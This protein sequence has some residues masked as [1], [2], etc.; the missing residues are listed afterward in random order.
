[1]KLLILNTKQPSVARFWGGENVV[2]DVCNALQKGGLDVLVSGANTR[3]AV[4]ALL[5]STTPDLVFANGCWLLEED[6]RPY[7]AE[8]LE[9]N[10]VPYVGSTQSSL[11]RTMSKQVTKQRLVEAELPTPDF[12][13][14]S[15]SYDSA[16]AEKLNFPT[17]IKSDE[18]ADSIGI[19]KIDDLASLKDSVISL[20]KTYQ[21][22]VIVEEY[23]RYKEYTVAVLGNGH[24]RKIMPLEL[25]LPPGFDFFSSEVK[26]HHIAE[27][28]FAVSDDH[29]KASIAKL[30]D[31]VCNIFDIRDWTRIELLEDEKGDLYII[32]IN[33]LPGL[34]QNIEHPSLY[35]LC[36][37]QNLSLNYEETVNA[38]IFEAILR[39]GLEPPALMQD[40]CQTYVS[41]CCSSQA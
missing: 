32:D 17:I 21:K 27:V 16:L 15:S 19:K 26:E 33:S 31:R 39:T 29:K 24:H 2:A 8:V 5:Q 7:I 38:L 40:I 18:N 23:C 35:P 9:R 41:G 20:F 3:K 13:V 1:M 12:V 4:E 22:P 36:T 6:D 10:V 25:K 37:K 30:V 14:F 34:R 11:A 28:W